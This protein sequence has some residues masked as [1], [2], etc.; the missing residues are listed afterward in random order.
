MKESF[1]EETQKI[2]EANGC[3]SDFEGKELEEVYLK[4]FQE[5]FPNARIV[6]GIDDNGYDIKTGN[7]EMPEIQVKWSTAKAR[8]FL[9]NSV[10]TFKKFIPVCVGDPQKFSGSEIVQSIRKFGGFAG[11][12]TPKKDDFIKGVVRIRQMIISGLTLNEKPRGL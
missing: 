7:N 9:F 3:H 1:R 2:L 12:D 11:P 6:G 5:V 10:N 8:E 4:K